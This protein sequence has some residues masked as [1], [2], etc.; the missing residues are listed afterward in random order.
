MPNQNTGQARASMSQQEK[1]SQTQ[2]V[3]L[4]MPQD[5][6]TLENREQEGDEATEEMPYESQEIEGYSPPPPNTTVRG[7]TPGGCLKGTRRGSTQLGGKQYRHL[8]Y[9]S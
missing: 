9:E 5:E 4:Q 7:T 2:E 3:T 6:N 1:P 8:P